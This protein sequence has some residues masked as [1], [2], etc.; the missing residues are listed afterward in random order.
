M[1]GLSLIHEKNRNIGTDRF[2]RVFVIFLSYARL[3]IG[4]RYACAMVILKIQMFILIHFTNLAAQDAAK[5]R[6]TKY[7]PQKSLTNNAR[8]VVKGPPT[9]LEALKCY[10]FNLS[11][12]NLRLASEHRLTILCLCC[13]PVLAVY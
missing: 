12:E 10:R 9:P 13:G 4:T 7:H 1:A 2:F 8:S 5:Q 11:P 3:G 6:T